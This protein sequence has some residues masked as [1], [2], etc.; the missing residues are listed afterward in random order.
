MEKNSQDRWQMIEQFSI[1]FQIPST[2]DWQSETLPE[3]QV[4]KIEKEN[5]GKHLQ[6]NTEKTWFKKKMQAMF[7]MNALHVDACL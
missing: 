7:L 3:K 2:Y 1:S 6:H 4:Q 5:K